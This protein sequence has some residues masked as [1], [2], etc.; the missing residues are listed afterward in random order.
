MKEQELALKVWKCKWVFHM[1]DV[2]IKAKLK[3]PLCRVRKYKL[4]AQAK[5]S[6]VLPPEHPREPSE[7]A[8]KARVGRPRKTEARVAEESNDATEQPMRQFKSDN[9]VLLAEI[10]S[11]IKEMGITRLNVRHLRKHLQ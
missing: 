6:R 1:T 4:E 10:T 8:K 11:Y 5:Y 7:E 9:P 2:A 3:I